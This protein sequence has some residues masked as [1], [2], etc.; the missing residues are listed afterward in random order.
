MLIRNAGN[1]LRQ[2]LLIKGFGYIIR[3]SN[4]LSAQ[5]NNTVGGGEIGGSKAAVSQTPVHRTRP[6]HLLFQV[7][8]ND[9]GVTVAAVKGM[10]LAAGQIVDIAGILGGDYYFRHFIAV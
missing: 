6:E 8:A 5:D 2:F 1:A 3:S 7:E 9:T 4:V 10:E